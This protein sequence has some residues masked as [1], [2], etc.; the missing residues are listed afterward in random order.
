M[1]TSC[2]GPNRSHRTWREV[3]LLTAIVLSAGAFPAHAAPVDVPPAEPIG[4]VTG[5][6]VTAP[7]DRAMSQAAIGALAQ[8]LRGIATGGTESMVDPGPAIE[9]MVQGLLDHPATDLVLE[10]SLAKGLQ[11]MPAELREPLAAV[12]RLVVDRMRRE[13]AAGFRSGSR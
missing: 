7:F 13:L 3:A 2:T 5:P 11:E 10:I 12:V 8:I 4:G 6:A 1:A 9:R